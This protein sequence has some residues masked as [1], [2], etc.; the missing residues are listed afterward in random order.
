[1]RNTIIILLFPFVCSAQAIVDNAGNI[2][3]YQKYQDS[4]PG[5]Y[6]TGHRLKIKTD[7]LAVAVAAS[8]AASLA[9]KLNLTDT[10]NMVLGYLRKTGSAATLTSFPTLNQNTTGTAGGL[11]ANIAESQVT[12]L[13][14]DLGLK[15]PLAS[16]TFTGTVTV[17]A[18]TS[19]TTPVIGAA[20][21]TS[22]SVTGAI[23]SSGGGIGYTS[24]NGGTVTQATSKSTGVTLNE[25]A[26]DITLN[27][28]ALAAAAIVSFTLTNSTIAATDV[29]HLQH[30]ATGTFAA[31]TLNGRCA[32][33]SAVI[34][35]RNNTAGSL[36]EAIV[37]RYIIVKSVTN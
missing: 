33:G 11:S 27:A 36:G 9:L 1:M 30:Q 6:T 25:L 15:A 21:G 37:I 24:G 5:I 4:I 3:N 8:T 35:L 32:A 23:T 14:T 26:G 12:N 17:P 10:A 18:S 13:V 31:Y 34:S 7:S 22:L 29:V 19:F 2:I 16:P 28:A 20:T